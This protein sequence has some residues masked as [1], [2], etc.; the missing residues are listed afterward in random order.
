MKQL[1]GTTNEA[2]AA[3][4]RAQRERLKKPKLSK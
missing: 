3:H 2:I 1:P 4:L